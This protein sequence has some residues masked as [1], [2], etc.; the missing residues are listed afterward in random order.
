M[1][2]LPRARTEKLLEQNFEK[3]VLIYDLMTDKAYNLNESLSIVYHACSGKQTFDELKRKHNFTDDFIFFALDELKRNNLLVDADQY[4]S[5]FAGISR[6]EVIRKVGLTTAAVLPIIIG[7]TAPKAASASSGEVAC[8]FDAPCSCSVPNNTGD[9]ALC[10]GDLG[11][12]SSGC[13]SSFPEDGCD[14]GIDDG[15]N[16]G[17]CIVPL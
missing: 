2:N 11:G 14:C 12:T 6:R 9:G 3:E 1:K 13:G 4:R 17:N 5:P 15:G 16:T 10:G 8:V 7:L